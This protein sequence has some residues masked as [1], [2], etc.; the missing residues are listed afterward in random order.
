MAPERLQSV[1]AV[2]RSGSVPV[3]TAGLGG[4][5]ERADIVF[6]GVEQAGGSFEARVFLNNPE[7]DDSTP[8]T[9]E[10]GYAGS[11]H[12][13]GYGSYPGEPGPAGGQTAPMTRYVTATD[14]VRAA[15]ASGDVDVTTVAVGRGDQAGG[16]PG[17]GAIDAG[18]VSIRFDQPPPEGV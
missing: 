11:F 18:R 3:D 16:G 7:A 13:Y 5:F 4:D 10:H 9:P 8:R 2:F 12:V 6:D 15:L 14:A 1:T 17:P